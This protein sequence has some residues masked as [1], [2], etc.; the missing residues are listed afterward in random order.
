MDY[1][2]IYFVRGY[3]KNTGYGVWAATSPLH[4]PQ[5]TIFEMTSSESTCLV[6][7]SI[8]EPTVQFMKSPVAIGL[9]VSEETK[10]NMPSVFTMALSGRF[11]RFK[12]GFLSRHAAKM[13]EHRIAG[14]LTVLL[15]K[16]YNNISAVMS[17]NMLEHK[18]RSGML[19]VKAIRP[20][21]DRTTGKH[22]QCRVRRLPGSISPSLF[23]Y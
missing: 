20:P 23:R 19:I 1:A 10:Q 4:T 22:Q 21:G 17:K 5:T 14:D 16:I 2:I 8:E 3:L 12:G 11:T 6:T 18:T 15:L 9:S 13:P 7:V